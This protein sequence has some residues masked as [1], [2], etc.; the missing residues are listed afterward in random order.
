M[1]TSVYEFLKVEK[2]K[3]EE[4]RAKK[5]KEFNSYGK[6]SF[7][8]QVAAQEHKYLRY[9]VDVITE[10]LEDYFEQAI[11]DFNYENLES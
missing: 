8:K 1:T 11:E 7:E 3:A 9:K 4:K 5:F 6:Y 2:T 10:L